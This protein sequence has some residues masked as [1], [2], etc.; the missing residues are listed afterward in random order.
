M[1]WC[2]CL[3]P[4]LH[5][6]STSPIYVRHYP[7]YISLQLIFTLIFFL[8]PRVF[9]SLSQLF[10]FFFFCSDLAVISTER[11]F[12]KIR[13]SHLSVIQ[14]QPSESHK[15]LQLSVS[16]SAVSPSTHLFTCTHRASIEIFHPIF[17]FPELIF[18]V[19]VCVQVFVN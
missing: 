10:S 19:C 2:V 13:L 4:V 16:H 11:L 12:A 18:F 8:F 5:P 3:N 9:Q 1:L 15:E 7:V 17:L 14:L 6:P